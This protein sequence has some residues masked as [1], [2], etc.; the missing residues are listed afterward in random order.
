MIQQRR[1]GFPRHVRR[2]AAGPRR[3]MNRIIPN[4]IVLDPAAPP[5]CGGMATQGRPARHSNS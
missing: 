2:A 4:E 5:F 3:R 1:D